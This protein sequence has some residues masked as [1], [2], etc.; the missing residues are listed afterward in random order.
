[1]LKY[2][3]HIGV[4]VATF[5]VSISSCAEVEGIRKNNFSESLRG[6]FLLAE[7]PSEL[8]TFYRVQLFGRY[9]YVGCHQNCP[10]VEA[11]ITLIGEGDAPE[12]ASFHIGNGFAW[13]LDQWERLPKAP[14]SESGQSLLV[15]LSRIAVDSPYAAREIIRIR[16]ASDG[17]E[18]LEKNAR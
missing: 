12:M 17:V 16:V 15:R 5:L 13:Q 4:I 2:R 18:I 7:T 8:R 3:V 6:V 11:Y 9:N 1:M 10:V 14:L